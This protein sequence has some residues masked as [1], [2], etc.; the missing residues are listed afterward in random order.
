MDYLIVG[1]LQEG[2]VDAHERPGALACEAC[3]EGHRVLLADSH[4][5]ETIRP[6]LLKIDGSRAVGHG[7]RDGHDAAVFLPEFHGS[8]P[9]HAGKARRRTLLGQEHARFGIKMTNAVIMGRILLCRR[10]A[11]ALLGVHV[12][13]D[14]AVFHGSRHFKV[15]AQGRNIVPVH[16]TDIGET[17]SLEKHSR[18]KEGLET[19]LA[20]LGQ[21]RQIA[22]DARDG[23]QEG[24]HVLARLPEPTPR[25]VAR[26]EAGNGTH[27]GGDG[28]FVVVEH[29]DEALAEMPGEIQALKGLAAGQR[30][31]ADDSDDMVV[32][33]LEIA[34]RGHAESR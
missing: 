20:A 22:A 18:G 13:K 15:M 25:Q 30:A 12:Q 10:E 8:L 34:G 26:E 14:G 32:E 1:P 23:A 29:H 31:I 9:E 16:R 21:R 2:G 24:Q 27:V 7:R 4:I 5:E 33:P 28:H 17:E 11:M 6:G 19:V 3:C